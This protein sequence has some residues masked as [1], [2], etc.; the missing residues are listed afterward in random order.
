MYT[1]RTGKEIHTEQRLT[2]AE[3]REIFGNVSA[4][5]ISVWISRH[6]MPHVKIGRENLFLLSELLEWEK[7]FKYPIKS[8]LPKGFRA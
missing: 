1:L 2:T 5:T 6:N 3:V 7:Q 4:K 8:G